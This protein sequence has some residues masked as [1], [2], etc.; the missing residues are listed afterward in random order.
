MLQFMVTGKIISVQEGF[1]PDHKD[2]AVVI[3]FEQKS[4]KAGALQTFR[5]QLFAGT[6]KAKWAKTL[7]EKGFSVCMVI[8]DLLFF[9][10]RIANDKTKF[11]GYAHVNE[12][13]TL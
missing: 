7:Q 5:W 4:F 9:D 3:D 1:D 11:S 10:E 13:L 12:I 8:D 2:R 6:H